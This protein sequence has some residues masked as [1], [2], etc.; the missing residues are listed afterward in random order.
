VVAMS[1]I[2]PSVGLPVSERGR[3]VADISN[4]VVRL[5]KHFYGKGPYKA[6][7]Y[8]H[9]NLLAVV[10]TGGFTR[11]EQTLSEHGKAQEVINSR[12]AMQ[13]SVEVEFRAQIEPLLRRSVRSCMSAVDPVNDVQVDIF[14]LQGPEDDEVEEAVA[15]SGDLDERVR[16]ARERSREVLDEHMALVSEQQQA[17][18]EAVRRAERS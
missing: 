16:R 13:Q 4:A 6:R 9:G 10:L 8:L 5:H 17:T 15:D 18:R 7:S 11:G 1:E 3:L 2:G 14:L 12:L